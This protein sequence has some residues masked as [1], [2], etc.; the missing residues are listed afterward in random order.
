MTNK[1]FTLIELLVVI[2]II[3]MLSSVVLGSLNRSR[4]KAR[5]AVRASDMVQIRNALILYY[6]KYGCLPRTAGSACLGTG[7]YSESNSGGWDYSSQGNFMTFLKNENILPR[8]IVD[9]INNMTGDGSPSGTYSYRYFC[10]TGTGPHLGY[11]R[12]SDGVY[13]N[14]FGNASQW[15]D[16]SY[17]CG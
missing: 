2:A 10:Y 9:P 3:G 4:I 11:W 16:T 12:E 1:G 6:D 8:E 13:V 15:T 7:S 5:D 14:I 17:T